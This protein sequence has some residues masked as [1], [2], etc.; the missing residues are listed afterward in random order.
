MA[1]LEGYDL[2]SRPHLRKIILDL[3]SPEDFYVICGLS[4]GLLLW[5]SRLRVSRILVMA[6]REVLTAII[7]SSEG[8]E[9]SHGFIWELGPQSWP[10]LRVL[11][12]GIASPEGYDYSH[13]LIWGMWAQSW[14]HWVLWPLSWPHF[15]L[16]L[17]SQPH[18]RVMTSVMASP[19]VMTR[20]TASIGNRRK[21]CLTLGDTPVMA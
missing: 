2:Q 4:S 11:T 6:W 12:P 5:S 17:Q 20:V 18:L 9:T 16:W 14:P 13:G 21:Q 3:T 10:H 1:T 19:E 8:C 7:A 15:K